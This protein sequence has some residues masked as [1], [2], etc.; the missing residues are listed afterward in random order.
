MEKKSVT[1]FYYLLH[2]NYDFVGNG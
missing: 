1:I 2:K